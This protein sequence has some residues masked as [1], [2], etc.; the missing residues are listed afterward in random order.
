MSTSP[1]EHLD[2]TQKAYVVGGRPLGARSAAKFLSTAI[3]LGVVVAMGVGGWKALAPESINTPVSNTQ[4]Q[5]IVQDNV[6]DTHHTPPP[7]E[8]E[9]PDLPPPSFDN[10]VSNIS[11]YQS[12]DDASATPYN[13]PIAVTDQDDVGSL[14]VK[15]WREGR[16][17]Q[18]A[19]L[20]AEGLETKTYYIE[21]DPTMAT[22]GVGYNVKRSIGAIGRDG[23]RQ[24]LTQ[25]GIEPA[26]IDIL[27]NPSHKVSSTGEITKQ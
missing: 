1:V 12:P 7:L 24:E 19:A 27:M 10:V 20:Q 8:A 2:K 13:L 5:T 21:G 14:A 11:V 26:A 4:S 15:M 6:A 17:F 18:A 23:V 25:A 3:K 16:A 9:L 22:I